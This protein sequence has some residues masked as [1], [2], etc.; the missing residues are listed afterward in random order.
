[1]SAIR[2]VI[3]D[4][5]GVLVESN[6]EKTKAFDDL[7]LL[8]PVQRD[9]MMAYHLANHSRPR[10]QKLE[11][12]VYE[13]MGRRDDH[14][15]VQAM[16]EQFSRFVTRRVIACP[17]VP[18]ARNFLE[19]FRDK[20]P[21]YVSSVTPQDE[22]REIV[23]AREIGSYFVEVF[24]DPPCRKRDAISSVLARESLS[25]PEVV[26]V[27][28]SVSDY[29]VATQAGLQFIGRHSGLPFEGIA[30]ELHTDLNGIADIVRQRLES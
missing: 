22:L 28:D 30:V 14:E 17:D 16:A 26:F 20:V 15:L 2:A 25:P 27:G 18:G 5:D 11:H 13:L 1:V 4:F 8:Y 3:L 29:R 12:Y 23:R 6:E 24:G 21:L 19:E 9:A 7:F 10:M